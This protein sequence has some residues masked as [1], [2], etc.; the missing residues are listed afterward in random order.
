MQHEAAKPHLKSRVRDFWQDA[1]CGEQ[2][3]LHSLDRGG[4]KR[5]AEERYRLEPF[6]VDFARFHDW[7]DKR[8]LE[9]GVGLGAD[10]QRFVE[11]GAAIIGVDLTQKAIELTERRLQLFSLESDLRVGDAEGLDLP[12]NEFDLV[13]S[14]GVIHHSPDTQRAVHEIYRVLKPGGIARVMIYNKWSMVGLM[15]WFRYGFFRLR[16][17]MSLREVYSQYLESPGTKAYSNAEARSLFSE[18]D[19]VR[20]RVVLSHGDLLSSGAG[21]RHQGKMLDIARRVWPRRIIQR[22]LSHRGLFMMI[23]AKKPSL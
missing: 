4:F 19:D 12:D 10:H 21:Q 9:I 11:S 16:P 23:E 5:Q 20:I 6:I 14:W 8:V 18:F 13:Y 15:L 1:A 3:L 22:F 7:R 17:F 2:L